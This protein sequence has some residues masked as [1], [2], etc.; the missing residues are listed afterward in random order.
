M[1]WIRTIFMALV[2]VMVFFSIV[3][4]LGWLDIG[5]QSTLEFLKNVFAGNYLMFSSA[6]F[7]I[8]WLFFSIGGPI[9]WMTFIARLAFVQ[10]L[11]LGFYYIMAKVLVER[12]GG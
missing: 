4:K 1:N 3:M 2:S 6:V 9:S 12:I 7:I 11:S 5:E 10:A 8:S